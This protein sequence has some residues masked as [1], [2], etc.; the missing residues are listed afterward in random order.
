M[1]A[2]LLIAAYP[3]DHVPGYE[4]ADP[5]CPIVPGLLDRDDVRDWMRRI[6]YGLDAD[7]DLLVYLVPDADAGYAPAGF[8]A[9][10]V[11]T[12]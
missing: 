12:P 7:P 8:D 2:F 10:E 6:G 11:R 1:T 5:G 9:L 4:L 3:S